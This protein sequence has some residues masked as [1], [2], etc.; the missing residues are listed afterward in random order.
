MESRRLCIPKGKTRMMN[1]SSFAACFLFAIMSCPASLAQTDSFGKAPVALD[2][3][4]WKAA[5]GRLVATF[6]WAKS[7]VSF[8]PESDQD[9]RVRVE[10]NE[11]GLTIT[12]LWDGK[13]IPVTPLSNDFFYNAEQA[14]PVLMKADRDG[15]VRKIL[16]LTNE[17]FRR[18]R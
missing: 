9:N 13:Q 3:R 10:S 4:Q 1:F 5:E 11:T 14:F 16:L 17:W 7:E 15:V 6:L 8:L 18:V 12:Q 2:E